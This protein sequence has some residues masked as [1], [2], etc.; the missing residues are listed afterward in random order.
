MMTQTIRPGRTWSGDA[1]GPLL[2]LDAVQLAAR[3][4]V[5]EEETR[6]VDAKTRRREERAREESAKSAKREI[7]V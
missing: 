6:G 7:E 1:D 4:L 5:Y 3:L 2:K